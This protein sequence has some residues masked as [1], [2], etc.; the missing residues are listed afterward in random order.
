MRTEKEKEIYSNEN[1]KV[2]GRGLNRLIRD[3]A[4]FSI[5]VNLL[6]CSNKQQLIEILRDL[7]LLY[8][9]K[10]KSYLLNDKNYLEVLDL[11]EDTKTLKIVR[12]SILTFST[13]Y[14]KPKKCD[15]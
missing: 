3:K 2:L 14:I 4:G 15:E 6:S 8:F 9:R 12:D 5:Q 11:I 7:N 10:Y 13:I 1:I